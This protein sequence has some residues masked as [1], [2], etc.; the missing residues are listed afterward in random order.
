MAL[1]LTT[2]FSKSSR[3]TR[4]GSAVA[5]L[6]EQ[7]ER[8]CLLSGVLD[9]T[10]SGDGRTTLDF[11]SVDRANAVV[12]QP[13]GKILVAGSWDGGASDFAIARFNVD[14][15]LDTTFGG[16]TKGAGSGQ[17]NYTFGLPTF[18][19]A[20]FATGMAIQ[21]DGKIVVVGY[22][23][24][25]GSTAAVGGKDFAVIRLDSN[26][27]LDTSFSGDGKFTL[28]FGYDDRASDVI[29]QNDGKIV[30]VGT[31]NQGEQLNYVD[32]AVVRLTSTGVLDT[33]FNATGFNL[34]TFG[35]HDYA[36]GVA[37]QSTGKIILGGYTDAISSDASNDFG[38]VRYNTDGT[39]DTTFDTDGKLTINLSGGARANAVAVDKF[40]RIV[41]AGFNFEGTG[42]QSPAVTRLSS[43]GV[44]DTS[45]GTS[46]VF[47]LAV[48][49]SNSLKAVAIGGDGSTIT[50]GGDTTANGP[51][52][53]LVMRLTNFGGLDT[54]FNSLAATPGYAMIATFNGTESGNALSL[55]ADDKVII[56]GST[57]TGGDDFA[58]A[59]LTGNGNL[60]I[61]GT[62]GNDTIT[63][64]GNSYTFNGTTAPVDTAYVDFVSI[65]GNAGADTITVNK[66]TAIAPVD[67]FGGTGNDTINVG[68][69]DL[70]SNLLRGVSVSGGFGPDDLLNINDQTDNDPGNTYTMF[71]FS[72]GKSNWS[73][74]VSFLSLTRVVVN[75][76]NGN[77][78][79]NLNGV[80][81]GWA[82]KINANGGN[83]TI[84]VGGGDFDS[85]FQGDTTVD[86]G[87]GTDK[88]LFADQS[89]TGNDTFTL[90]G[91]TFN[92][93]TAIVSFGYAGFDNV[94]INTGIGNDNINAS[95][96]TLP[97][98]YFT[99][100]GNDTI[101]SGTGNDLLQGGRGNDSFNGGG[102]NDTLFGDFDNDVLLGGI[103]NDSLH[104]GP[105][106]D[107]LNGNS[108]NDTLEGTTGN[109]TLTDEAGDD[110]MYGGNGD[111]VYRFTSTGAPTN[112][113][114]VREDAGASAGIDLLDF[115]P[116][117]VNVTVNLNNNAIASHLNRVVT[118]FPG[119]TVNFENVWGG[120]GNDM[121]T[122]NA[123]ANSLRGGGGDDTLT[124]NDNND[125][126]IGSAGNDSL[127][128]GNG[129]DIVQGD[130]GNDKL[131]GKAGNDSLVGL[132]GDDS[133]DGGS[134]DDTLEG[135]DGSDTLVGGSNNDLYAFTST[136]FVQTDLVNE[137][138]GGGL[139]TLDFGDCTDA[140]T[141]NLSSDTVVTQSN[142]TVKTQTAGLSG[143]FEVA[144]GGSAND[145]LTG[146]S[147][148]NTLLGNAGNDTL[149]GNSG[150]DLLDGGDG[151][152]R[153][154]G[155]AGLDQLLGGFGADTLFGGDG[156][157]DTLDGGNDVDLLGSSDAVDVK[158]NIP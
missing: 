7:M 131:F 72:L 20:E 117:G 48:G 70:D 36:T 44:L 8:R 10:F 71:N 150:N 155:D 152:D 43:A 61:E 29:I 2:S 27:T 58:I 144:I 116:I 68:N 22:T 135:G 1:K 127:D 46:G 124:G 40:D 114:I 140:V 75:L 74:F 47:T 115:S 130:A 154:T 111:D 23:D 105:D 86:G 59:R 80:N 156:A 137:Q 104:G 87:T 145:S 139:D 149:T 129:D 100:D 45:F 82:V 141:L 9:N 38:I 77:E 60:Y 41:L 55:Q 81:S 26:G 106:D 120:G 121:F 96:A 52:D 134:N 92:K 148:D 138:S 157:T 103:G 30:V 84:N 35:F 34:T 132:N 11:G 122:G 143:N 119:S 95:T 101:Q 42:F 108:G 109:D 98:T 94:A 16:G 83:D 39:I 78:T 37:L 123:L 32:F 112:N 53:L 31:R 102:G 99:S 136:G 51:A 88:L 93:N 142:R 133:L 147:R 13:D 56:A 125:T 67:A 62:S 21:A 12:V 19:G 91:N 151:N 153:L 69:G 66:T 90:T 76:P 118:A 6:V 24:T 73:E 107:S 64:N 15:T 49:G 113:D 57:S 14:G 89:D 128:G 50:V 25:I 85:N 5:P 79:F 28:D 17:A 65:S 18:G 110:S 4:L 158:I 63:F 33:T 97:I 3:H 126:L 146:N 54:S